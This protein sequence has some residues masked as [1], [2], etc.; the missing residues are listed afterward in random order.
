MKMSKKYF[1]AS[2]IHGNF[3]AW[4]KA[5]DEAGF[6]KDNE[7]HCII[8]CGDLMDRC[9]KPRECLTFAI[10]MHKAGRAILIKG[11][12]EILLW[13][14]LQRRYFKSHDISNGT[15]QTCYDL[16]D[17]G[18]RASHT[19]VCEKCLEDEDLKYYFDH[20]V[21]YAESDELIFCHSWIPMDTSTAQFEYRDDWREAHQDAWDDYAMW[22]NPFKCIKRGLNQTGKTMVFGHWHT[23]WQRSHIDQ[24]YKEFPQ[25]THADFPGA[26]MTYYGKGFTGLDAYTAY[27]GIINVI[28]VEG[29]E[30]KCS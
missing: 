4:M 9:E 1:V 17:L 3:D 29:Q 14:A 7:N 22:E 26:F 12:H 11:N 19:A 15:A 13:D 28:V 23:S 6:D 25:K 5:L 30:I 20:L 8:V 24:E 18:G 2:D 27:S 16:A 21:N 10:N